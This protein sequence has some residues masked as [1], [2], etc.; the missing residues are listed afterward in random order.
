[1]KPLTIDAPDSA[2]T[3]V[4]PNRMIAKYSGESNFSANVANAFA[5]ITAASVEKTPPWNA[6]NSVQ[7][8]A[9][10]GSPLCA[11]V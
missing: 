4:N 10:A 8:S 6:A 7:P 9:F 1:M 5:I 3:L 2:T 11:I